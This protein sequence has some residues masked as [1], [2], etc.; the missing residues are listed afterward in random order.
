MDGSR[1]KSEAVKVASGLQMRGTMLWFN[2]AKD[3]GALQTDAGERMDV[4]GTAFSGEKPLGRCAGKPVE[5]VSVD[6]AVSDLAFVP[7]ENSRRA[8][9]RHRR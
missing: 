7:E 8:R 2:A 6:G 3:L 4:P 9:M 5:F 1:E